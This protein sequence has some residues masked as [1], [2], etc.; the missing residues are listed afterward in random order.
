APEAHVVA[1]LF[2]GQGAQSVG[3]GRALYQRHLRFRARLDA[4]AGELVSY[5]Y[6]SGPF[7]HAAAT[8][9]LMRT[10]ICQPVMAAMGMA[11]AEFAGELGVR[12]DVV[13]G[14]SLGEIA[15]AGFAGLLAAP[16]AMALVAER[17]RII[18]DLPLE[19]AGAMA[20]IAAER[21]AVEPHLG[22]G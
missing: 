5:L 11:V 10:E 4:H 21:A 3:L 19:D 7:D 13:L 18:R 2:P 16:D 22:P 1:F 8:R 15:A 6:P 12:P 9:A 14:H 17:G 20:A